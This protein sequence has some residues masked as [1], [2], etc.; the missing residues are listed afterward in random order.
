MDAAEGGG[1]GRG[2]G[3]AVVALPSTSAAAMEG[4][5]RALTPMI[6][7]KGEEDLRLPGRPGFGSTGREVVVTTNHFHVGVENAT[8][9]QYNVSMNPEPKSR[10]KKGEVLSEMVELHEEMTHDCKVL[11]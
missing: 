1:G 5:E 8:I 10:A 4:R 6:A 11:A 3:D 7:Y 9:Y 2:W